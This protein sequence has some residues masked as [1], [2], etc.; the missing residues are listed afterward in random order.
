MIELAFG[1]IQPEEWSTDTDGYDSDP[2]F[3]DL[4]GENSNY[5]EKQADFIK[6]I[7]IGS[8]FRFQEDPT[9]TIY[10]VLDVWNFLRVRYETLLDYSNHVTRFLEGGDNLTSRQLF[11]F[12]ARAVAGKATGIQDIGAVTNAHNIWG[13]ANWD[14][15]GLSTEIA[16]EDTRT[17]H[18]LT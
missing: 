15:S 18:A 17:Q 7:A 2:S 9:E 13:D 10:T 4:D 16:Q 8:Q 12:H 6:H 14:G 3:Y 5:S 11:P 1:A